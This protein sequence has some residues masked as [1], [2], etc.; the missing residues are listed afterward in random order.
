MSILAVS[1]SHK[2][3][4]VALLSQLAMDAATTTKLAGALLDSDHIDEAVVLSTCNRT[5][6]YASVSRFH[7]GLD[8]ATTQLAELAGLSVADLQ[9]SCA[10][11]FDEG[12]VA[13]PFAVAAGLDSLV[14]GES[15]ILGQVKQAL[16]AAR[17]AA[18]SAPCSTRCSS[19]PCGSASG[20]RARP[21]SALPVAPW[22]RRRTGC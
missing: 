16:A 20:C 19:R 18:P 13:H 12:A 21:T 5:E 6:L 11:Y 10:V 9:N 2:T 3:G 7:G 4:D 8:D 14:V 17:V 1:V 15:Q 22:S